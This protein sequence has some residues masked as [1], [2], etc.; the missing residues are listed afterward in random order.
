MASADTVSS[1][2]LFWQCDKSFSVML[3][4]NRIVWIPLVITKT[5]YK[6]YTK[7]KESKNFKICEQNWVI[8]TS[9]PSYPKYCCRPFLHIFQLKLII[10]IKKENDPVSITVIK[11]PHWYLWTESVR[12]QRH[13]TGIIQTDLNF[14]LVKINTQIK[15]HNENWRMGNID[16]QI[17]LV[18]E[19]QQPTFYM[20]QK[21]RHV[22]LH[23]LNLFLIYKG[24]FFY[25]RFWFIR[26]KYFCI[27]ILKIFFRTYS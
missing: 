19:W 5:N 24:Y 25:L 17:K 3:W 22:F 4:L 12:N 10:I 14:N 11:V 27:I 1:F 6:G 23:Q 7:I 13:I 8:D 9:P 21:G 2:H 20:H 26:M 16:P 15:L 18:Y